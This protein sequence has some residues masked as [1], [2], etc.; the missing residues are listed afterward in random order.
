MSQAPNA[1]SVARRIPRR[2]NETL[3]GIRWLPRLIDKARM[4]NAGVLG[5]YLLGHSPFDAALLKRLGISTDD[6]ASLVASS[7]GDADVLA[8]LRARGFDEARVR[9]WSER[10]P[11]SAR[12]LIPYW[13]I[14]D[15]YTSS[16]W[17]S[18]SLVWLW[19]RIESPTMRAVRVIRGKP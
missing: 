9:R 11:R 15:G 13:D 3:D 5:A 7:S 17:F 10:L 4:S 1:D 18:R 16:N 12:W 19:R 8:R 14:D 6:F 2:W